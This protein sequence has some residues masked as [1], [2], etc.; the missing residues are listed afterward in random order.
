MSDDIAEPDEPL[1]PECEKLRVVQSVSHAQG[2]FVDWLI[3]EKEIFL[4]Q[5]IEDV[6]ELRHCRTPLQ[7]LLAEFHGIDLRKVEEERR[8]MLEEIRKDN[9]GESR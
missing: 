1:Y 8:A 6:D 7:H 5:Y 2:E 4:A 9:A 3:N